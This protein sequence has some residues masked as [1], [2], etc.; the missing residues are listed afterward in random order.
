MKARWFLLGGI[1]VILLALAVG[2]IQAQ[3]PGQEGE[4]QSQGDVSIAAT[5]SSKISY[6][7]MLKENG[8]PVNG[9][10]DM[11]FRLYSDDTC[12]TQVGDAIVKRGVPVTNG[13]FSVDLDVDHEHFNG[14]SLWLEVE[15]R[16][17][18]IGCQEILPVP[19]ALGLAPGAAM[20]AAWSGTL[21]SVKNTEYTGIAVEG[22]ADFGTG[23]RGFGEIGVLGETTLGTGVEGRGPTGVAGHS[24]VGVGVFGVTESANGAGVYAQGVDSGADLILGGN[25][26]T[27]VGDDGRIYSDP[28]YRSSDIVLISNDTVRIDLDNDGDGEDADFEIRDKDDNLIFDVDESGVIQSAAVS[29]IFVPGAE[30]VP[31][32][33]SRTKLTLEYTSVGPV[34]IKSSSIGTQKIVIPIQVPAVLYGQPVR[35]RDMRVQYHTSNIASYI[36]ETHLFRRTDIGG[37]ISLIS[38]TTH[39]DSIHTDYY[40]LPCS[41]SGCRLDD[42]GSFLTVLLH[43]Y[44]ANTGHQITIDGVRLTLE[45]D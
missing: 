41:V 37:S 43:L 20:D 21:F 27:L 25:A 14:Q 23:V 12:R 16:G 44:F 4:A 30:A 8:Q 18:R 26:D 1:L 19:Y 33:D 36:S 15:V 3:G 2:L 10:R 32:R 24:T 40:D 22:R 35:I 34:V 29:R 39:R 13:L 9:S 7:G 45:H 31:H 5:V 38:N 6:Q 11:T 28:N 42:Y 17:T